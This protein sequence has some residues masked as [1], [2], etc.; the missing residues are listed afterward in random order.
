MIKFLKL[1]NGAGGISMSVTDACRQAIDHPLTSL[2][3]DFLLGESKRGVRLLLDYVRPE[4][5]LRAWGVISTIVVIGSARVSYEPTSH[6]HATLKPLRG[7]AEQESPIGWYEHARQFARVASE[8]GGALRPVAGLRYNVIA[9]GGGPGIMEAANR[10]ASEAGAPS[11]GF[12]IKLPSEQ[13]PNAYSTPEL[14]FTFQYFAIRKFHLAKRASAVVVFPGGFGTLDELFEI[15]NLL[16]THRAPVIPI[17]CYDEDYWTRVINFQ[18]LAENNMIDP[19]DLEMLCFA[20]SAEEAW[21]CLVTRGIHRNRVSSISDGLRAASAL[22]A[23]A[24]A[25]IQ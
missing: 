13:G 18:S 25:R 16:R 12:N 14:T 20:N 19:I 9:T 2:D 1:Q 6:Q 8:R 3:S 24:S 11:I 5:R 17:V 22:R 4:E 7:V 15:L 23:H 21:Q 10:G